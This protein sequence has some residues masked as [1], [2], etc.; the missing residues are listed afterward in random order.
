MAHSLETRVPFLDNDLVDFAPALPVNQKLGNIDV[1]TRFNEND[2][3]AQARAAIS[4]A[5]G[6]ARSHCAR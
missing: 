4:G 5:P 6:T 1:V 2:I 3:C